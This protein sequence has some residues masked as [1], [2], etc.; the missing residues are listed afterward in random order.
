MKIFQTL[1]KQYAMVGIS[2]SSNLSNQNYSFNSRT[3]IGFFIFGW[4]IFS[5]FMYIFYVANGFMEY[6]QGV[7]TTSASFLIFVGFA[8]I[9]FRKATLFKSIVNIEGL[10]D[11]REFLINILN[12]I[13]TFQNRKKID[14][15]FRM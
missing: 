8:A 14:T 9:F 3:L 7:C 4:S 5:H 12:E 6:M 13:S 11:A 15:H 1:Q 10:I 2:R